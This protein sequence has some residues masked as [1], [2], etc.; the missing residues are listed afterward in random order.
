MRDCIKLNKE[1]QLSFQ[2]TK[3]KL[4]SSSTE[5]PFDFSEMYI[6]GKFDSFVRRC[7]KIIDIYSIINM[8]SCLA[9]SKIEGISSFHLK[10]NGMVITL[11]KQDYDFLDQR[12]QEVDH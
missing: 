7:E 3:T 4:A 2:L 8:Y 10:F 1:Y 6:F 5:R 11:K 9:E 12:K